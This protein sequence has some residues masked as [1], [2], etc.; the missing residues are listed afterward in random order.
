MLIGLLIVLGV[1][2]VV[3]V[4]VAVLVLGRRRWLKRQPGEFA[5]AIRVSSGGIDGISTKWKRG[6]GR[7]VRDVL[8]WSK[9]PFM[10]RNELVPIDCFLRER[11]ANNGEVKRL[12]DRPVII[13]FASSNAKIEVAARVERSDRVTGPFS[14]IH[15]SPHPTVPPA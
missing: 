6:S 5:G 12:G 10:F 7:G 13:E 15:K 4:A 14:A 8:V 11:K 9:P 1:N 3:V 2:L